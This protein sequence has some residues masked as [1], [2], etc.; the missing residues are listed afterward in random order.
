MDVI[1]ALEELGRVEP[2]GTEVL[3]RTADD[4]R[5]AAGEP[6]PVRRLAPANERSLGRRLSIVGSAILAGAAAAAIAALVLS[7]PG[8]PI[9]PRPAA[10]A[11]LAQAATAAASQPQ[12]PPLASGQ[13]YYEERISSG[14]CLTTTHPASPPPVTY[15]SSEALQTWT[16][17]D[18]SG[19]SKSSPTPAAHFLTLQ[20]RTAASGTPPL[21][22]ATTSATTVPAN[23]GDAS[24]L[25]L[26]TDP[27]TLGALFAEGR[28]SDAGQVAASAPACPSPRN[29]SKPQANPCS[30]ASQ[31]NVAVNLL[32]FPTAAERL[33]GELFRILEKLPG[34]KIIGNQTDALGRPGTAIEDPSS[35]IIFVL[36]PTTGTLLESEKLAITSSDGV[37]VGSTLSTMTYG[38]VSVVSGLGA[39]PS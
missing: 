24:V 13:Y 29:P 14:P 32:S 18:G 4:L 25:A 22:C 30:V 20:E 38:P 17:T 19:E 6:A 28:V 12:L 16:T 23:F 2:P 9:R 33:G 10:A 7:I 37:P 39:L 8:S 3:T 1:E 27:R 31:F 21:G 34:V 15:V 35:G 11:V 5:M 36:N 26:P